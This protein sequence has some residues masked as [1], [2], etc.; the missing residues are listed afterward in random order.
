MH[1]GYRG[2][3]HVGRATQ[4]AASTCKKEDGMRSVL[5]E[6]NVEVVWTVGPDDLSRFSIVKKVIAWC[7]LAAVVLALESMPVGPLEK[8]VEVK[9][10]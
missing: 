7:E 5:F 3:G 8:L 6:F 1:K 4:Q 10:S 2:G 9:V